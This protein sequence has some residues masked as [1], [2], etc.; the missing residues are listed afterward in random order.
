MFI[1]VSVIV[2]DLVDHPELVL[3]VGLELFKQGD[4]LLFR[5][6]LCFS[7]HLFAIDQGVDLFLVPD[8]HLSLVLAR[9]FVDVLLKWLK[10]FVEFRQS[11]QQITVLIIVENLVHHLNGAIYLGFL[12]SRVGLLLLLLVDLLVLLH[13]VLL[14]LLL[15]LLNGL[16]S[17][18][19]IYQFIV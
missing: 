8:L 18:F 5:L 6:F 4:G 17:G 19:I 12:Q 14:Q 13:L 2:L 15:V 3:S 7:E 11:L 1:E 9:V 16:L 10:D